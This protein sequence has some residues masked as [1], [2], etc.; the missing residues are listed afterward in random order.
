[1][2]LLVG[3]AK[4]YLSENFLIP[5]CRSNV[6]P[7]EWIILENIDKEPSKWL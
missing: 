1:M 5:M 6:K 4:Y 3:K 7:L 2:E